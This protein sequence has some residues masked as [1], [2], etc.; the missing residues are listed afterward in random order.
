MLLFGVV[1]SWMLGRLP[2]LDYV[3]YQTQDLLMRGGDARVQGGN[4]VVIG[5]DEQAL[6]AFPEPLV[7]WHK[8]F[9]VLLDAARDADARAVGFDLIPRLSLDWLDRSHDISLFR[10][11]RKA[12]RAGIPVVLG[13]DA[14]EQGELPLQ[15]F[16]MAS[17]TMGYL[18]IWPDRDGVVRSYRLAE[19][20]ASDRLSS[21]AGSLARVVGVDADADMTIA[22]DYRQPQPPVIS[23]AEVNRRQQM[24]DVGWLR[25]Q[26]GGRVLLLGI[27]TRGL[28]DHH[29]APPSPASAGETWIYGVILHAMALEA[30]IEQRFLSR[31][32]PF[33]TNLLAVVLATIS[34]LIFLLLGPLRA[35]LLLL[36]LAGLTVMLVHQAF[37][38]GLVLLAAPLLMALL[39]PAAI[40]GT[41]RYWVQQSQFRRLQQYFTSYVSPEVM[42]DI[43]DRE[44][45]LALGGA[46]RVTS[47][48]FSDIRNFT[49]LSEKL[50][51]AQVVEGLNRYFEAMTRE[52]LDAG[53]HVN[54]YLGDGI[55]AI[56]GAPAS[57]PR[58][59][60][61]AAVRAGLRMLERL[62]ELNRQQLFPGVAELR[63][64]IGIH[65][66]DAIVGNIGCAE[67]MDYSII[68]DTVNLA[69]RIESLTKE[70]GVPMLITQTTRDR[71]GDDVQVEFVADAQVRGRE[72]DVPLY[73]VVTEAAVNSGMPETV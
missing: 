60:A 21:L 50:E 47:V 52:I 43:I 32:E 71:L 8:R 13:F 36:L 69:S 4:V 25:Q 56:F 16:Q 3:N 27:T 35:S 26:L 68:G 45:E 30:L 23:L 24:G 6:E 70:Y 44:G 73:R 65:T 28:H 61:D 53:G 41:W 72:Q 15:K 51:P 37:S 54:R 18:N 67:K 29:A 62:E 12:D 49:T 1:L 38:I 5:I 33:Q 58:D 48:M 14:G 66:G 63:I 2:A 22:L 10:A 17:S 7:L 55:L 20:G 34:G 39:V 40:G 64:G 46:N 9:A 59:G 19:I 57:L 42:R 31:L 11:L